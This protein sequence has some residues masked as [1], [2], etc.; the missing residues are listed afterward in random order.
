MMVTLHRAFRTELG[1]GAFA[2]VVVSQ[3]PC[4]DQ[5]PYRLTTDAPKNLPCVR[6]SWRDADSDAGGH[7]KVCVCR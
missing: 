2:R 4:S 1:S 3:P 7:R 6:H 5:D